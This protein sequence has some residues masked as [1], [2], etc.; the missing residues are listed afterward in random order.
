[1]L[2]SHHTFDSSPH[3]KVST[4]V[5][6][7]HELENTVN[8]TCLSDVRMLENCSGNNFLFQAKQATPGQSAA[9]IHRFSPS[10]II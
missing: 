4:S 9:N 6:V 5:S 2:P 7:S 3:C 10:A 1:V 8:N